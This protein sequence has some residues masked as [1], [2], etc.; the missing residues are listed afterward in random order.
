MYIF[1][2]YVP[3][4]NALH[5][6]TFLCIGTLHGYIGMHM[7]LNGSYLDECSVRVYRG[8]E[9]INW[10]YINKLIFIYIHRLLNKKGMKNEMT[11]FMA[12]LQYSLR[13]CM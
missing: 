11:V 12:F 2:T 10:K 3:H 8:Y 1:Y 6:H 7:A 9:S 5:V 13:K 4:S